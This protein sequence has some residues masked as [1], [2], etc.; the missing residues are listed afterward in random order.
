[1]DW[2]ES[3]S[4]DDFLGSILISLSFFPIAMF[5]VYGSFIAKEQLF[6]RQKY[7]LFFLVLIGVLFFGVA[8]LQILGQLV[9]KYSNSLAENILNISCI[10]PISLGL[11]YFK[12]G[13]INQ[14]QLQELKT[15]TAEAELNM[16]KAQINP[17]FLF[18]TLNNIYGLNQIDAPRASEMII[19]LSEVMRYHLEFSKKELIHLEDEIQ[20]LNAYIELEKLRLNQHCD[21]QIDFDIE[22]PALQISPL[23]LLPFVENAFKHGAHPTQKS[24]IYL[25]L[26]TVSRQLVFEIKNSIHYKRNIIKT[27]IGL[28]NT[29]RRLEII[30]PNKHKL[31]T[32]KREN[33]FKVKLSIEL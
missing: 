17:H 27:N 14:Y 32:T 11:Q 13:I 7:I 3:T 31:T 12:R 18:N 33:D 19:E 21:L 28:E 26:K 8:S 4:Q 9:W 15:K 25:R 22:N 5:V 2:V 30:Y 23:L 6:D 10:I 16:L 24:Y 20:L 1:M 29:Q